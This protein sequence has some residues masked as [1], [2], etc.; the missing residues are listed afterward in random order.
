MAR[1]AASLTFLTTSPAGSES[2]TMP[3]PVPLRDTVSACSHHAESG[4]RRPASSLF[5][6]FR[7]GRTW[8]T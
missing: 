1:L 4:A 3:T 8:D 2:L 6:L 7:P 5:P